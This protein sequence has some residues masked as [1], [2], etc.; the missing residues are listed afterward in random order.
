LFLTID[1][2]VKNLPTY[3]QNDVGVAVDLSSRS[4]VKPHLSNAHRL[5]LGLP[6]NPPKRRKF[7]GARRDGASATTSATSSTSVTATTTSTSV[8]TP[9][10]TFANLVGHILVLNANTSLVLGYLAEG[11]TFNHFGVSV[12]GSA[13]T[14]SFNV[15][16]TATVSNTID[17]TASASYAAT[18]PLMG[19]IVGV[20]STDDS[21]STGSSNYAYVQGTV[22]TPAGSPPAAVSNSYPVSEH[23]ESAIWSYNSVTLA[24]T[25]QWVNTDS[26]LP[27]TSLVYV[28]SSNAIILTGD[29]ASFET[30]FSSSSPVTFTFVTL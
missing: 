26:S 4:N 22:E 28:S 19:G 15:D 12:I 5:A 16:P 6:L 29:V 13:L 23:A 21:L 7:P 3:D 30:P 9:T 8:A 20:V 27:P 10:P 18:W 25:P 24:I 11:T 1:G 17:I 2:Y 14:V